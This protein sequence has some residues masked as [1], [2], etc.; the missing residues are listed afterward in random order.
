MIIITWDDGRQYLAPPHD[1]FIGHPVE[2]DLYSSWL[3]DF[4]YFEYSEPRFM[5]KNE[6]NNQRLITH[7]HNTI[8]YNNNRL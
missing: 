8:Q 5:K 4:E 1:I 6:K 2:K 3:I 7:G